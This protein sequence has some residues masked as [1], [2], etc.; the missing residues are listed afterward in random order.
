M[1]DKVY[2]CEDILQ[3]VTTT[4]PTSPTSHNWFWCIYYYLKQGNTTDFA[5]IMTINYHN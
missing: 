4:A 3:L 1:S 2:F 5:V